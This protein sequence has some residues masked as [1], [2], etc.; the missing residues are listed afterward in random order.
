MT[1]IRKYTHEQRIT[2]GKQILEMRSQGLKP[3][4]IEAKTGAISGS[5]HYFVKCFLKENKTQMPAS[6]TVQSAPIAQKEETIAL[7]IG[8]P[9]QIS[10]ALKSWLGGR[11]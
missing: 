9:S 6:V 1:K 4:D 3:S 10:E 2:W 7:L 8:K 11:S 5:H